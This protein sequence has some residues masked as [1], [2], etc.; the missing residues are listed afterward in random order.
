MGVRVGVDG[1]AFCRGAD[2]PQTSQVGD[3]GLLHRV[4]QFIFQSDQSDYINSICLS[5]WGERQKQ[6]YSCDL[7]WT[8]AEVDVKTLEL[9]CRQ[10]IKLGEKKPRP[11]RKKKYSP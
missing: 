8:L 9:K 3:E 10:K 6:D 11:P 4:L 5:I 2:P 1:W 7:S